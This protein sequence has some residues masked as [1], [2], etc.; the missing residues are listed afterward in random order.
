MK[1][2]IVVLIIL[3]TSGTVKSQN[4]FFLGDNSYTCSDPIVLQPNSENGDT[5][6]VVLAKKGTS[7][8]IGVSTISNTGVIFSDKLV[9][10]LSD[11][12]TIIC[13]D[14]GINENV[15]RTTKA[16]FSLTNDELNTFKNSDIH[17]I[18]YTLKCDPCYGFISLEEGNWSASIKQGS[19][20]SIISK[21]LE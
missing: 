21:F 19:T 15:D 20:I 2:I 5:L 11:G 7:F 10:Y 8:Y 18:K 12:T 4:L 16:L 3:F 13:V 1:K 6:N 17:T 9:I 14:R